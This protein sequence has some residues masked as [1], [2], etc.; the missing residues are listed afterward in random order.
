LKLIKALTQTLETQESLTN[1]RQPQ[2]RS[3][4]SKRRL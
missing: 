4:R 2:Q 3:K 1:N